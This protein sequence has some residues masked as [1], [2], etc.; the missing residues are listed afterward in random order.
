[1]SNEYVLIEAAFDHFDGI[2][3]AA[4]EGMLDPDIQ[5][6]VG[7]VSYV[8]ATTNPPP[9]E[10]RELYEQLRPVMNGLVN[11]VVSAV[12]TSAGGDLAKLHDPS[13]WRAPL[14]ATFKAFCS[15][16]S[17]RTLAYDDEVRGTDV[18]AKCIAL[19]M[20][21]V[22]RPDATLSDFT[23]FLQSQ[24]E[25]ID[26]EVVPGQPYQ[27]AC[28]SVIHKIFQASDGR[29]T[30]VPKIQCQFTRFTPQT[31]DLTSSCGKRAVYRFKFD[32][33]AVSAAF[34]VGKWKSVPAFRDQVDA[35]IQRFQH[36]DI[37]RSDNY[38]EGV[39]QSTPA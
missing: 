4:G 29:W 17:E 23:S 7:L 12:I 18:A 15:G 16:L 2:G 1:M 35:F 33:N 24:G 38:F 9:E 22:P 32:V 6:P 19:I 21:A 28:I 10:V 26:E 34:M 20:E 3:P 37:A 25:T 8:V 11:V 36:T 13:T 27:Y 14:D 5:D 30:Y 31:L 39:F